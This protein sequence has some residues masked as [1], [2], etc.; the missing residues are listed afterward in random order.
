MRIHRPMDALGEVDEVDD[1]EEE[2]RKNGRSRMTG[3]KT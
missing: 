1:E 3:K 2:R